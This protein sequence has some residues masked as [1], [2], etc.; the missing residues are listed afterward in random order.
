MMESTFDQPLTPQNPAMD[1]AQN[2]QAGAAVEPSHT[3]ATVA[4]DDETTDFTIK[5]QDKV[6]KVR[7]SVLIEHS[8]YFKN[9]LR[10][11]C[12]KVSSQVLGTEIY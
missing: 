5:C 6:F 10:F 4:I 8:T 9:C 11:T 2:G 12:G 7:K 1:P 3:P